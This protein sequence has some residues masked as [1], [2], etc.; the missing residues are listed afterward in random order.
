MGNGGRVT[1]AID[2]HIA[3]YGFHAHIAVEVAS[4]NAECVLR[5]FPNVKTYSDDN[6]QLRMNAGKRAG[7]YSV[8]R[9]NN[10]KLPAVF[11]SEITKCEDF[12]LQYEPFLLFSKT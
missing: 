1:R 3:V 6:E 4:L 9:T 8:K 5:K 10:S 7:N 2:D 12:Y 11:L